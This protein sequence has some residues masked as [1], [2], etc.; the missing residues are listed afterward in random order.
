MMFSLLASPTVWAVLRGQGSSTN[1]PMVV[2]QSGTLDEWT[3]AIT[4]T[5]TKGAQVGAFSLASRLTGQ[6]KRLCWLVKPCGDAARGTAK[7]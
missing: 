5:M 1:T 3:N 2:I 7:L 6:A 4:P